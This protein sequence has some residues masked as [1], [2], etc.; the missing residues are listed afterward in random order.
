[1]KQ[2][3]PFFSQPIIFYGAHQDREDEEVFEPWQICLDRDSDP[4]QQPRI[5]LFFHWFTPFD[6]IDFSL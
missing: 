2:E 1:M 5:G 6:E 4:L 3:D